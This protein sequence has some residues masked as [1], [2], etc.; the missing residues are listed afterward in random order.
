[1][2]PLSLFSNISQKVDST[3]RTSSPKVRRCIPVEIYSK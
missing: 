1:M 3:G 2:L